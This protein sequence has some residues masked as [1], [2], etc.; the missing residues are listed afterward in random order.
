MT[1]IDVKRNV[2]GHIV[3]CHFRGHA[4]AG[5][6]GEDIVCAAISMLSQTSLLGLHEVAQQSMEYRIEDGELDI[7][8]SEPITE[9]GQTILET[10]LLGIKN[11]ADQY[12][13]FVRV[14]EQ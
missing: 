3:E 10:M 13:D 4:E 6:C 9:R 5:P 1:H 7:L 8:L 2:E 12:S 11:V 14:S